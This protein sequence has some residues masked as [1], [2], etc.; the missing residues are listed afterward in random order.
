MAVELTGSTTTAPT[1]APHVPGGQPPGPAS[2][3]YAHSHAAIVCGITPPYRPMGQVDW[4]GQLFSIPLQQPAAAFSTYSQSNSWSS[5]DGPTTDL[6]AAFQAFFQRALAPGRGHHRPSTDND[7]LA[8]LRSTSAANLPSEEQAALLLKCEEH[9]CS[10]CME[11]L[12]PSPTPRSPLKSTQSSSSTAATSKISDSP[13][14]GG[15]STEPSAT[16]ASSDEHDVLGL[17]CEH[18]FH[19]ECILKWL[20]MAHCC[21]VCRFELEKAS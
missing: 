2:T 15:G 12:A 20:K 1:E 5:A 6:P 3:L 14:A 18:Y 11:P 21:P 4:F 7:V 17:P 10:I 8:V 19:V 9:D 13:A 16:P